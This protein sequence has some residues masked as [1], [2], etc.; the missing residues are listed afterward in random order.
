[1]GLLLSGG[2]CSVRNRVG[3]GPQD[4]R[5]LVH[6]EMAESVPPAIR[7][8]EPVLNREDAGEIR[9]D[10]VELTRSSQCVAEAFG[11]S[12]ESP[13]LCVFDKGDSRIVAQPGVRAGCDQNG[14]LA[15]RQPAE[16][17]RG[18]QIH[19]LPRAA[20]ARAHLHHGSVE[21]LWRRQKFAQRNPH[22]G[23]SSWSRLCPAR[24]DQR[25]RHERDKN[26]YQKPG[27]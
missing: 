15:L 24:G 27:L 3:N 8:P 14:I 11:Q 13:G 1:M 4:Q 10:V 21:P 25:R 20:I 5:H 22:W 19:A 6:A 18:E 12:F 9:C 26:R 17:L 2:R 7:D 16:A 23:A